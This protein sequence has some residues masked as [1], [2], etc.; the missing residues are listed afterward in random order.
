MKT[1]LEQIRAL[2]EDVQ[3]LEH[4]AQLLHDVIGEVKSFFEPVPDGHTNDLRIPPPPDNQNIRELAE[5]FA[6]R[7]E[8]DLKE[9]EEKLSEIL[10]DRRRITGG[11]F[12]TVWRH[13]TAAPAFARIE[14]SFENNKSSLQ[15]LLSTLHGYVD[16]AFG[17]SI[18]IQHARAV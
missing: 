1:L 15:L 14:K 18:P 16:E 5:N 9:L 11:F 6:S 4:K 17:V 2:E 3:K 8:D 10:Q 7:C 12:L 13:K